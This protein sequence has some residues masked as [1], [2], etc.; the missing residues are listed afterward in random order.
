MAIS[1]FKMLEGVH[2]NNAEV[3]SATLNMCA[4]SQAQIRQQASSD[5]APQRKGRQRAKASLKPDVRWWS[6]LPVC[7]KYGSKGRRPNG[8]MRMMSAERQPLQMARS[9]ALERQLW[10]TKT[11]RQ[12][13]LTSP[14][15]AFVCLFVCLYQL[16]TTGPK[17][18]STDLPGQERPWRSDPHLFFSHATVDNLS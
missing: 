4:L 6:Y 12:W 2:V 13:T 7:R 9:S 17:A 1:K 3:L 14:T 8:E 10:Q 15:T 11:W 16:E 5:Q 18:S